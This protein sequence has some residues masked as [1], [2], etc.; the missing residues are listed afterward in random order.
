MEIVPTCLQPVPGNLEAY[1]EHKFE[2]L[3]WIT[4]LVIRVLSWVK[5]EGYLLNYYSSKF[6][7]KFNATTPLDLTS[8]EKSVYRRQFSKKILSI[9]DRE[10][11]VTLA[12]KLGFDDSTGCFYLALSRKTQSVI[13]EALNQQRAKER[14][15][16]L[17]APAKAEEGFRLKVT[18]G[19]NEGLNRRDLEIDNMKRYVGKIFRLDSM[20]GIVERPVKDLATIESH[21][22][23]FASKELERLRRLG[24]YPAKIK[25]TDQPNEEI[26]FYMPIGE[27]TTQTY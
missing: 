2:K 20:Y 27:L 12:G 22:L 19:S 16:P 6:E 5:C 3:S 7:E 23:T 1:K 15:P 21:V 11:P 9:G 24:N 13:L 10:I 14:K 17:Q 4:K 26:G 18:L 8:A 25:L